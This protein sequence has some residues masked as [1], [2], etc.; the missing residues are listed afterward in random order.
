MY[1]WYVNN[2][3]KDKVGLNSRQVSKLALE[4]PGFKTCLLLLKPWPGNFS[5]PC[6]SSTSCVNKFPAGFLWG[7]TGE[8]KFYVPVPVKI[9]LEM[10]WLTYIYDP[11]AELSGIAQGEKAAI[12]LFY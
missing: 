8:C 10:L 7:L 9:V 4:N 1:T 12:S 3:G 6:L 11:L 2:N 5:H